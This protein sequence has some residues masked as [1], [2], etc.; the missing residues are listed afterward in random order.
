MTQI[1]ALTRNVWLTSLPCRSF[2]S[3]SLLLLALPAGL[4]LCCLAPMAVFYS[5]PAPCLPI[6]QTICCTNHMCSQTPTQTHA[7]ARAH[8]YTHTHEHAGHVDSGRESR[9]QGARLRRRYS[10][11]D[12]GRLVWACRAAALRYRS[13]ACRRPVCCRHARERGWHRCSRAYQQRFGPPIGG[14]AQGS[15]LV[16]VGRQVSGAD[17][18]QSGGIQRLDQVQTK[19][20]PPCPL[21]LIPRNRTRKSRLLC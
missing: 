10:Y 7:Q 9:G 1:L 13:A 5:L 18:G 8:T 11:S 17:A 14:G 3:L 4:P 16:G 15:Q 12:W 2:L 20:P 6:A 21:L 19:A